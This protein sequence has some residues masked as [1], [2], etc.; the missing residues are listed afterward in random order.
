MTS[1]VDEKMLNE[2]GE[3]IILT[4]LILI[5]K[6]CIYG[7]FQSTTH[8][9]TKA[10]ISISAINKLVKISHIFVCNVEDVILR[11][12]VS[13]RTLIEFCLPSAY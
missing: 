8:M 12:H 13:S 7:V 11:I 2:I 4:F 9:S 3:V 10:P 6:Y 1:I 5:T